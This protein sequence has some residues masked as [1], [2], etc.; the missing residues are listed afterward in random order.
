MKAIVSC[1]G[2][3]SVGIFGITTEID[4]CIYIEKDEKDFREWV[5]KSLTDFFKELWDDKSTQ[6][7]FDDEDDGLD[8]YRKQL[9]V[10]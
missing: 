8:E 1:E 9:V 7:I 2:D 6:V 5:R 10:I 4:L 3:I